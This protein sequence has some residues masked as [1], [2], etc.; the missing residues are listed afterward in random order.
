VSRVWLSK[1]ATTYAI[2]L[3]GWS[4]TE[5]TGDLAASLPEGNFTANMT[6]SD[7]ET[8]SRDNAVSI[9]SAGGGE[10]LALA[11]GAELVV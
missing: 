3:T 6:T 1:G 5:V 11:V 10:C 7:N 4:D 9:S 2:T 8:V